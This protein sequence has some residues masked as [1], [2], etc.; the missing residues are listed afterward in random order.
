M[1]NQKKK[2]NQIICKIYNVIADGDRITLWKVKM[3]ELLN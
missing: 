1:E 3:T 2:I